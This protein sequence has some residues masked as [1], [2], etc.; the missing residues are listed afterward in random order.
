MQCRHDI[1]LELANPTLK[2]AAAAGQLTCLFW[3]TI[4]VIF[5]PPNSFKQ[6]LQRL[7]NVE[8]QSQAVGEPPQLDI[9]PFTQSRFWQCQSFSI[10]FCFM[11]L[12]TA[13]P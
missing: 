6:W 5:S 9:R 11:G 4:Y 2:M 3:R 12:L 13:C 1:G 10:A 8:G 7:F